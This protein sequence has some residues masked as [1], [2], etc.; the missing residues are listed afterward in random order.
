MADGANLLAE[1]L[2]DETVFMVGSFN[3]WNPQDTVY[4]LLPVAGS[5]GIFAITLAFPLDIGNGEMLMA[6]DMIEYKFTKTSN[7]PGNG[8]ANGIKNF[9]PVDAVHTCP[10]FPNETVGLFE[11]GNLT[12][13][14]PDV[15]TELQSVVVDAWRNY[16]E[17]FGYFSCN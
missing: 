15:D 13:T 9:F 14:I 16:A 5:P 10:M 3:G 2:L 6:G 8:W 17:S 4:E 1:V 11:T 12:L 7:D